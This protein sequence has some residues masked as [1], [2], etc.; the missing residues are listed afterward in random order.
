MARLGEQLDNVRSISS[1]AEFIVSQ[2]KISS[3]LLMMLQAVA[4]QFVFVIV[5]DG[6]YA[7]R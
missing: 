2:L 3:I 5:I 4:I 6:L 7:E 1:A